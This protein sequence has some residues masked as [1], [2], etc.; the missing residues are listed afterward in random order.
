MPLDRRK[1]VA[2]TSGV[3]KVPFGGP[4]SG[5]LAFQPRRWPIMGRAW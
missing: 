2:L 3:T 4:A 5:L 1:G